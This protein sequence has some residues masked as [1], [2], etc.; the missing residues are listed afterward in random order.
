MARRAMAHEHR[1]VDP[2]DEPTSSTASTKAGQIND[3]PRMQS[4]SLPQRPCN[5]DDN[6]TWRVLRR[7]T[8][9]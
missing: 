3:S 7:G 6:I 2:L 8:T 9:Y 4:T 1:F 5:H